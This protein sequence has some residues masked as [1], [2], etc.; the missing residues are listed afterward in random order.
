MS[1]MRGNPE[2]VHIL[3]DWMKSYR[4]DELST[5]TAGLR[6]NSQRLRRKGPAA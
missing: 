5:P 4:P 6:Q 1:A 3:E 2:H